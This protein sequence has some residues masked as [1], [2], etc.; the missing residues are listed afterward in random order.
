[1]NG[2]TNKSFAAYNYVKECHEREQGGK[3]TKLLNRGE[4]GRK[5]QRLV[6]SISFRSES[7]S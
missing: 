5:H 1:M 7:V 2:G 6:G 4:S 3:T